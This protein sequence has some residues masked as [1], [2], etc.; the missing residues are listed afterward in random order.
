M[1]AGGMRGLTVERRIRRGLLSGK[2]FDPVEYFAVFGESPY[3][4]LVPDLHAVNVYVEHAAGAF[5]HLSV[6]VKLFFDRFRQ[7]GGFGVVVS[8]YAVFDAD[9]HG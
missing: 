6:Y 7:T 1:D 8:L 5:D 3:F 2:G 9:V 4:V